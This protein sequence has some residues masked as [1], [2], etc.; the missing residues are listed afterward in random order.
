M[1]FD[2]WTFGLQTVNFAVLVWLLRRF[3]YRPVMAMIDAR[4][5]AVRARDAAAAAA[6]AEAQA[7]LRT[8]EERLAAIDRERDAILAAAAARAEATAEESRTKA[9]AEV[10]ALK[11]EARKTLAAE[12]AH[13]LEDARQAA[14]TLGGAFASRLLAELP[15]AQ[16]ADAWIEPLERHLRAMP[17][18]D[19]AALIGAGAVRVVTAAALPPGSG[20]VWRERIQHALGTQ[21][22]IDFAVD[23]ALEAG[24]EL[25]FGDA[26]LRFSWKTLMDAMRAE[27]AADADTH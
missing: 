27:V 19:R 7:R 17:D 11:A 22:A 13:A 4:D 1:H 12:R 21:A 14:L 20:A 24:A 5:A 15:A 6:E 9:V 8:V 2:W 23:P 26:V 3:L 18:A 25:H 16:V 10:E